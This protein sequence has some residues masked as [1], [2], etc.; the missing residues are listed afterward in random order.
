MQD[1]LAATTNA[2]P[3]ALALVADGKSWTYRALNE[4]VAERCAQLIALGVRHG[5]HVGVFMPNC[6]EYVQL[7]HALARIG[8]VLV[9]L[10]TRLTSGE[11][12]FQVGAA[13]CG[14]VIYGAGTEGRAPEVE[15]DAPEVE[16]CAPEA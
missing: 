13:H 16:M 5:D 2:R 4:Q 15:V 12:A 10:N 1:W 7:I 14:Y 6:A 8:A 9:P 3:D 11:V